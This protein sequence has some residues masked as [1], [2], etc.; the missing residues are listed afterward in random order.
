MTALA[1]LRLLL[2]LASVVLSY[3]QQRQ[4]IGAGEAKQIA[5]NL[6]KS[7]ELSRKIQRAGE[8]AAKRWDDSGGMPDDPNR[9]D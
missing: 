5:A 2:S 7:L 6:E 3:A 1:V 8:D 4:L 9:R